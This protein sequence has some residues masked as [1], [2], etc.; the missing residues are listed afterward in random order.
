MIKLY[1]NY[2]RKPQAHR[3]TTI[4][5][6]PYER[7]SVPEYSGVFGNFFHCIFINDGFVGSLGGV[8]GDELFLCTW[9][10]AAGNGD[11]LTGGRWK[12]VRPWKY[13][14]A[15]EIRRDR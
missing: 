2:V 7:A 12:V 8:D 5:F 10:L 15:V 1:P 9:E 14:Q 6:R 13:T 11:R 3:C 4:L